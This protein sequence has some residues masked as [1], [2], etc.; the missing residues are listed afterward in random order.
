MWVTQVVDTSAGFLPG[1][2]TDAEAE[3]TSL[4]SKMVDWIPSAICATFI[5][6]K[7]NAAANDWLGLVFSAPPNS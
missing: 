6:S 7:G 2:R 3:Q 5:V 4:R 1:C